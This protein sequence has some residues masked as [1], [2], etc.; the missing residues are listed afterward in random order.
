MHAGSLPSMLC[1]LNIED[2][3]RLR[4]TEDFLFLHRTVLET[5]SGLDNML[6]PSQIDQI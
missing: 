5:M 1:F 3:G 6:D 2:G 4:E